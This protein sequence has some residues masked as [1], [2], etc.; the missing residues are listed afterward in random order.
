MTKR[1]LSFLVRMTREE[2]RRIES[3]M[4]I[5]EQKMGKVVRFLL[6]SLKLKQ[7]GQRGRTIE[8]DVHLF[9]IE[10]FSGYTAASGNLFGYWKNE[11]GQDSYG[12]HREFT[13]AAID[14][15][16]LDELKQFLSTLSARLDEECLY[17]EVGGQAS[18]LYAQAPSPE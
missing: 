3:I 13:V 18:L 6:P 4:E 10:T 8:E 17:L 2:E 5:R 15:K 14:E 1:D 12:E 9:L 7:A 11:A 16:K